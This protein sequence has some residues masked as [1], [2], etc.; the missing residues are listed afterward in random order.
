M[1]E[2]LHVLVVDDEK[3]I[4]DVLAE[5]LRE[6]GDTVESRNS[7]RDALDALRQHPFDLV[8]SDAKM[9]EMDGFE[10]IRRAR[11][12]Y[13]AIAILL[14]TAYAE[15]YPLSEAL[16]AGADGYITKPF[17]LEKFSLIFEQSYWK[18]L[19]RQDWWE[20]HEGSGAKG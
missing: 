16:E 11:R 9:A 1:I 5:Y 13:P 2:P 10:F 3:D 17:T 7:A 4:A 15:E 20:G 18:A 14:M 8:I 12:D 19:S 6:R